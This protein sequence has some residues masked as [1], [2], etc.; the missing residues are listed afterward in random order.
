[1]YIYSSQ[2][3]G[4][5]PTGV[6]APEAQKEFKL[7]HDALVARRDLP[8]KK[9]IDAVADVLFYRRHPERV[10]TKGLDITLSKLPRL[11]S[12]TSA[13]RLLIQEWLYLRDCL[14]LPIHRAM[15]KVQKS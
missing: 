14:V 6:C 13:E 5:F 9:R 8:V 4:E 3:L 7:I 2:Q 15:L 12:A 1:M 11:G 10:D